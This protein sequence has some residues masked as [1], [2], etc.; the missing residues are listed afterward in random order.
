MANKRK[1]ILVIALVVVG[2]LLRGA[3]LGWNSYEH[4]DVAQY[5]AAAESFAEQGNFLIDANVEKDYFYSLK[6]LGGQH[7][8]HNPLWPFLGGIFVFIFGMSGY[9]ALQILS[10]ISGVALLPLIFI[11]GK[12]LGGYGTGL[13]ALIFGTFSYA[14]ID[15]SANGSFYIFQAVL[16]VLFLLGMLDMEKPAR[17]AFVWAIMGVAL[18]L[19]Q[20]NI[21]LLAAYV[22]YTFIYFRGNSKRAMIYV[23]CCIGIVA[24]IQLPWWIRNYVLFES[25][26]HSIDITYVWDKIGVPRTVTDHVISYA[27]T[28]QTYL[29]LAKTSLSSWLP[30]NLYFMH[31]KFFV[32][33]PLVYIFALFSLAEAFFGE[34]LREKKQLL[35]PLLLLFA[36]Y[37]GISTMWPIAKFRYLIPLLPLIF[38]LGS[39]YMTAHMR[40]RTG[41]TVS[42]AMSI[43]TVFVFSVLTFFGTPSHTYYYDGVITTD[44]FGKRGELDFINGYETIVGDREQ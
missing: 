25:P 9:H 30:H 44:N 24:V 8:E 27:V 14:L 15:F 35:I 39:W 1:E 18:L 32:V 2:I 3:L 28:P 21:V 33:A 22:L 43:V 7:L 16:Y 4:G 41:R 13:L 38:V 19:N 42:I 17:A 36:F 5:A 26:L 31:R 37:V 6:E 11:L 29:T 20:Q 40:N 23:L 12:K 34:K 10:F